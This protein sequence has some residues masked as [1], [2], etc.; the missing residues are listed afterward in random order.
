MNFRKTRILNRDR[1]KL[2][3]C[4]LLRIHNMYINATLKT[5]QR[6]KYCLSTFWVRRKALEWQRFCVHVWKVTTKM[7]SFN[8]K[9]SLVVRLLW[10]Q[11]D[12]E[13][14]AESWYWFRSRCVYQFLQKVITCI[15][16]S[17]CFLYSIYLSY[18]TY[19]YF[20]ESS[21]HNNVLLQVLVGGLS[22]SRTLRLYFRKESP[23][24]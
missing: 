23:V 17:T 15:W 5:T 1:Q 20:E 22:E 24:W 7:K 6:I 3:K 8:K 19:W 13:N 12:E 11:M 21:C 18:I 2:W 9:S 4:L 14:E 10:N 16:F